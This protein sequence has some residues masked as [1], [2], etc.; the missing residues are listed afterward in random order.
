MWMNSKKLLVFIALSAFLTLSSCS[1][2]KTTC[3]TNCTPTGN[4]KLSVTLF[5]TPPTGVNLLSFTLP[6][7]GISLTPST[8]SPVAIA[9]TTSSFEVTHLQTDS[10]LIADAVSVPSGSYTALSVTLGPTSATSNVF[11]NTSGSTVTWTT[12]S[13]GSCLNGAVCFL[14]AGA[15]FTVSIPL[16]LTLTSDQDQWI[17]LDLNLNNAVTTTGGLSVDFS[18]S[19]VLT[20][21]TTARTGMPSPAVDT[22]EDFV[23]VVTA[24][25]SGSSITVKSGISGQT[26]TA[27]L[28]TNT[29][30]D[31]VSSPSVAYS[32][33]AA[34]PACLVIGSTVSVDAQLA[35]NGTLTA[36]EVDVLDATAMDEVEGVIYPTLTPN[37]YGLILADKVSTT[38]N[39]ALAASTTTYGSGIFL[40]VAA[41]NYFVDTKTLSIPLPNPIGFPGTGLLAGQVVRAQVSNV[42]STNTGITATANNVLLRWSRLTGTVSAAATPN[43]NFTPPNYIT[44]LDTALGASPL[45]YTFTGYTAF[46]GITDSTGISTSSTVSIR[47]LLLNNAQP[48]FAVAKVRVP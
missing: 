14:P 2:L 36:T 21:I 12:G 9:T 31:F 34:S 32:N 44:V 18:Q 42:V 20:A 15:I 24:Y 45:A 23:G 41:A 46:D 25:S 30:Y 11:L 47:A 8:G 38:G 29:E 40:N 26:I 16:T 43:F 37:V 35:A 33:C 48:T 4:A 27:S 17:G 13:G 19:G 10:A 5:D 6:I 22:V 7:A 1:G 3:T 28:T 39:A